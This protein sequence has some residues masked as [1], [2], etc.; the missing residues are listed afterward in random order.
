MT[1]D[2]PRCGQEISPDDKRA[3][4]KLAWSNKCI[5]CGEAVSIKVNHL[6]VLSVIMI[7]VGVECTLYVLFGS[8]VAIYH[9]LPSGLFTTIL[10]TVFFTGLFYIL[11]GKKRSYRK[12]G[13]E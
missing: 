4:N 6:L 1:Y 12:N 10:M 8:G 3:V 11:S 5:H 13:L 9:E 7:I 2:C